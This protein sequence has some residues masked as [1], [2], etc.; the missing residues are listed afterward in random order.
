MRRHSA[1][2]SVSENR[3]IYHHQPDLRGTD[4]DRVEDIGANALGATRE[5]LLAIEALPYPL[6]KPV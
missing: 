5:A 6:F 4:F 1:P 2:F 3:R